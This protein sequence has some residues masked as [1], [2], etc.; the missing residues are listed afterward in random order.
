MIIVNV[1]FIMLQLLPERKDVFTLMNGNFV[2]AA[3]V[4]KMSYFTHTVVQ[5]IWCK[6]KKQ[7]LKYNNSFRQC[8]SQDFDFFPKKELFNLFRE[9]LAKE[10]SYPF[11]VKIAR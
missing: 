2:S 4:L 10:R 1:M 5:C 7:S 11:T 3:L 8:L 9:L 6:F